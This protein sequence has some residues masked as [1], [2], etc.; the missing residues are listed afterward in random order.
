MKKI[1]ALLLLCFSLPFA[2]YILRPTEAPMPEAQRLY[3]AGDSTALAVVRAAELQT[4][5]TRSY[6]PSYTNLAYPGG[7]VPRDRGVCSDVVVRAFRAVNVDLQKEVHEDMSH[8]FTA[9]PTIWKLNRPDP[10]ID[11]RRVANLM[12]FFERRGA[13][14][15]ITRDPARFLPGDVV[16]WRLDNGRLHI[17]IVDS[18]TT[19]SRTRYLVVHNIGNGTESNDVLFRWEIIGHY[20]YFR[21]KTQ[22]TSQ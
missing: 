13:A 16:A 4:T 19:E 22:A 17:G 11:H 20:R 14:L 15:G 8:S 21:D 6:D 1:T 2:A 10:N 18:A 9:Y 3:P 12:V 5:Y 7:D